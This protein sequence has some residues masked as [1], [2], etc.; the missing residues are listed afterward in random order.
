MTERP[1][2]AAAQV[3]PSPQGDEGQGPHATP[4]AI[5]HRATTVDRPYAPEGD[6]TTSTSL[7]TSLTTSTTIDP[8]PALVMAA[9]YLLTTVV[10]YVLMAAIAH[11][12]P[13]DGRR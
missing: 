12:L 9:F 8:G 1:R 6:R 10:P 3:D 5:G 13:R 7:T 11:H 4:E 2:D